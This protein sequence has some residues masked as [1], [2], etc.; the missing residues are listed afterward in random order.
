MSDTSSTKLLLVGNPTPFLSLA[1]R[2]IAKV[3]DA[4][5]VTAGSIEDARE[6]INENPDDFFLALLGLNLPDAPN[7]EIV[8]VV[9]DKNIPVIALITA[10]EDTQFVGFQHEQVIDFIVTEVPSSLEHL[11]TMVR[12]IYRN[13]NIKALVVSGSDEDRKYTAKLMRL[14]QLNVLE[15]SDGAEALTAIESDP[16][17]RLLITDDDLP[18]MDGF[19]L[20]TRLRKSSSRDALAIIGISPKGGA[21]LS[22]KFIKHGANDFLANPFS[23]EE[24][25]CRISQNMDT[26]EDVDVIDLL[27]GLC[28]RRHFFDLGEV[29]LGASR[30]SKLQPALAV[31][32]VDDYESIRQTHGL[33]ISNQVLE[34]IGS[35]LDGALLRNTDI[36]ARVEK[37]RFGI[38]AY[39]MKSE[40]VSAFFDSIREAIESVY[41][42]TATGP[43]L[44][45]VSIGVHTKV[46]ATFEDMLEAAEST[47]RKAKSNSSSRV[48]VEQAA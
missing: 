18:D 24:L 22:A 20:T 5:I 10:A 29:L 45:T 32:E 15:A 11:V 21:S 42:E 28:S 48:L 25:F 46:G 36:K 17:I 19:E 2:C 6:L 35:R 13:R 31:I 38:F 39:D 8:D 26:Q 12:R 40:T 1:E 43:I 4:D 34:A 37:S 3:I 30:R 7:G 23:P 14:F 27:T 44:T 47:L 33:D 16:S 41:V 9:L